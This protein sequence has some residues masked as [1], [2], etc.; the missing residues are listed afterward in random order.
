MVCRRCGGETGQLGRCTRCG[1]LTGAVATGVLTPLP[2][3]GTPSPDESET[4]LPA[5]AAT[6]WTPPGMTPSVLP[7]SAPKPGT[8]ATGPVVI[9]QSFGRYHIIRF[10]GAGGMGVVYHAWDEELGVAVALKVVR[11]EITADPA[12]AAQFE[13]RFKRE[14]LLAR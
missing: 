14:L 1:A 4:H 5:D 10:L 7:S 12:A 2:A 6:T 3:Q 13:T 11:S 8:S 9:G